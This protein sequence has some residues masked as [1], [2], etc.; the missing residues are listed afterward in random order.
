MSA[1]GQKNI[2]EKA[3]WRRSKGEKKQQ[4]WNGSG[5]TNALKYLKEL[6]AGKKERGTGART[7]ILFGARVLTGNEDYS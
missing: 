6:C 2:V 5:A 3:G 4:D 1:M 7:F